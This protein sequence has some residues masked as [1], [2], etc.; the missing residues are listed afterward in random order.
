MGRLY[1]GCVGN[2]SV[3]VNI[4]GFP[5]ANQPKMNGKKKFC[6]TLVSHTYG[7]AVVRSRAAML[8]CRVDVNT[9]TKNALERTL[10]LLY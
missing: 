3:Q 8:A 1:F 5:Q 6:V 10:T 7:I 9:R 4:G 2:P